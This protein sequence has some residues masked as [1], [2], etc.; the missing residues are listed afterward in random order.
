M[1]LDPADTQRYA[2]ITADLQAV[3]AD[4]P[5]LL[6]TLLAPDLDRLL[7]SEFSQLAALLPA[8]L[9]DLI[10]I[11]VEQQHALG[12]AGLWLW[13][14][15]SAFDDTL[16]GGSPAV[17][18]A[19]QQALLNALE[20]YRRLGLAETPAWAVLQ[21]QALTSAA[22]YAAELQA[23]PSELPALTEA[24]LAVFTP[25]LLMDRSAPFGFVVIAQ[26]TLT[27]AD[28]PAGL[29]DALPAAIRHLTAARQIA[30]DASDWVADLRRG[31][32]NYASARLIRHL[33]QASPHARA[34]LSLEWLAGHQVAADDVWHGLEQ[35]HAGHCTAA[36]ALLAPYAPCRLADLIAYQQ[37]S[38]ERAWHELR[39]HRGFIRSLFNLSAP[40]TQ[41]NPDR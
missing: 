32:L 36:T 35:E 30:D 2:A 39:R 20:G 17:L 26:L 8:W 28:L 3:T 7:R 41:S 38:D 9:S 13:W 34:A 15:A 4:Y 5:P 40:P 33:L 25:D 23:R 21:Q 27:P 24:N 12:R 6:Q 10:P 16:D 37:A 18:P 31:H 1:Q 29:A 19:A 11:S 22:A 14:Y